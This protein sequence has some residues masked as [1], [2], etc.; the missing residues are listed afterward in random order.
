MRSST[1]LR[2]SIFRA[3][4]LFWLAG[5]AIVAVAQTGSEP[6]VF[7]RWALGARDAGSDELRAITEDTK[8]EA[9]TQLKFLVEPLSPGAMYLM[10]LDSSDDLQVLYRKWM[11]P[12]GDT[13]P[14]YIPP[15]P[16]FLA[17]RAFLAV[18]NP[19]SRDCRRCQDPR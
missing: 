5:L 13:G 1:I 3:V 19:I 11:P 17:R 8:L 9:G 15:D 6:G 10:L 12:G 4:F 16:R 2:R 14:N 7:L 18:R